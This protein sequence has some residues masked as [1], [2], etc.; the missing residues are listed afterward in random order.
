MYSNKNVYYKSNQ[1]VGRVSFKPVVKP[2]LVY[3]IKNINNLKTHN[4]RLLVYATMKRHKLVKSQ[5]HIQ[6]G[7]T[8]LASIF[9]PKTVRERDRQVAL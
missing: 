6:G 9:K 8:Y 2:L 5:R 4:G 3:D 7:V 1:R